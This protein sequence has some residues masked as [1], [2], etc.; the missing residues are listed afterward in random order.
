MYQK[1]ETHTREFI[2]SANLKLSMSD[3][4]FVFWNGVK[5]TEN[6]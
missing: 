3:F 4:N 5:L 2:D 1:R 6:A